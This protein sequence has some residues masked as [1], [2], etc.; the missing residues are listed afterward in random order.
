MIHITCLKTDYSGILQRCPI[1]PRVEDF[2]KIGH[3]KD[4]ACFRA[5]LAELNLNLPMDDEVLSA[6]QGSPL[7]TPIEIHGLTVGNRWCIH[8]MEGW[9][10]T[11][12]GQPTEHTIRRW[13][14]F[15]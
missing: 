10:G 12:D 6:A 9:D 4:V 1:I 15:G 3:F 5:H 11:T 8:P 13:Q 2:P 14:H 7:A